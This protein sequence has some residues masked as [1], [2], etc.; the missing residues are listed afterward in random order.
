[1]T[2]TTRFHVDQ[3]VETELAPKYITKQEFGRR[4]YAYM[5]KKRWN[6]SELAREAGIA[7]DMVSRYIRGQALPTPKTLDSLALALGVSTADLLPNATIEG[8]KEDVPAFELK[9]SPADPAVA[10]LRVNQLVSRETADQIS[11][12]LTADASKFRT[13]S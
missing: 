2:N 10:Y 13:A 3:P 6:Q 12:L 4:V 7:R 8:V 9:V 1:M 5:L 11:S